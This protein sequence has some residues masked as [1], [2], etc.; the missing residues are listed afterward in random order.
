MSNKTNNYFP[1]LCDRE[2]IS[3]KKECNNCGYRFVYDRH[4]K[5]ARL[6]DSQNNIHGNV[7]FFHGH[8]MLD[9]KNKMVSV[10]KYVKLGPITDGI[11]YTMLMKYKKNHENTKQ[12]I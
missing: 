3:T 11:L 9:V 4:N 6:E 12:T 2:V 10:F 8:L 7:K 1:Y 5:I